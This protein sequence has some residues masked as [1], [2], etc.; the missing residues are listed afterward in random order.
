MR[1]D[2]EHDQHHTLPVPPGP[3]HLS[4]RVGAGSHVGKVRE[5]NQD[6]ISRF[7]CPL[8][9]VFLVVD[10]MGGHQGGSLAA[11][12]TVGGLERH[13][14]ALLPGTP[15]AEALQ[16][17]AVRTN[18]E[19]YHRAH[20]D[21]PTTA[22]MGAT[23]VLFLIRDGRVLVA[24]AGDSRAYLLRGGRLARLSRDHS[25]VQRMLDH[26][27]LTEE[28]ARDHPDASV[29]SRA[30]G[31]TPE[32]ELEVSQPFDVRLGDRLLLCSDGLCG[33]VDDR[34]IAEVLAGGA[35]AQETA[36]RL[37]ELALAA[38][39]EDNVSVQVLSFRPPG[40]ASPGA[41]PG[42]SPPPGAS[43]PGAP[44]GAPPAARRAESP[45]SP[46]A[47]SRLGRR[48]LLAL[49]GIV[50][51]LI[52][53]LL[54][55]TIRSW[56]GREGED[57]PSTQEA[58]PEG[59]GPSE[60]KEIPNKPLPQAREVSPDRGGEGGNEPIV[61]SERSDENDTPAEPR[62]PEPR[63]PVPGGLAPPGG[64][65]G[66]GGIIVRFRRSGQGVDLFFERLP[67]ERAAWQRPSGEPAER[68]SLM[69][70]YVYYPEGFDREAGAVAQVLSLR[71][72]ML[73][74]RAFPYMESGLVIALSG[75]VPRWERD[76]WGGI[77][78]AP[79]ELDEA[80]GKLAESFG[81][82]RRNIEQDDLTC[83]RACLIAVFE[84]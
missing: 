70:G 16:A 75:P 51:I 14:G 12:M 68:G 6:R 43:L 29:V 66:E 3:G 40:G 10:G 24:H 25:V 52:G 82:G 65:G 77:V 64:D 55:T 27:M 73:R 26:G 21:D 47:G 20:S 76:R 46:R 56:L 80:A 39:G 53:F 37:I 38:G 2:R 31:K 18:E 57:S 41:V 84:P 58:V 9:E 1:T 28:E 54:A 15:P 13:L 63:D 62:D 17:A 45:L 19:I 72:R 8:G 50:L 74:D 49:L 7:R 81:M 59:G 44:S 60:G 11:E 22:K 78:Y 23:A 67:G 30:F 35:G 32:L 34:A 33:Y 42:I 5:E 36:D 71:T 79:P 83:G 4:F 69:A 48:V 61:P